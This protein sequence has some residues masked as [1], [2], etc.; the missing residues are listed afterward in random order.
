MGTGSTARTAPTR[1]STPRPKRSSAMPRRCRSA[2]PQTPCRPRPTRSSRGPARRPR[3]G[4]SCWTASPT[5]STTAFDE[6]VPLVTGRDRRH[7]AGLQDHAGA[8]GVGPVPPLRHRGDGVDDRV[9]AAGDHADDRARSRRDHL[10]ASENRAPV[11]V[12]TCITS[13]NFP[14]VNMAGKIGPALAMGNT[15]VVK[16]APQDPLARASG[17]STC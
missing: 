11:G 17:W 7:H 10:R 16:P 2:R 13:Y 12:V 15:V 5:S 4:P 3:T 14:I 6:L 9:D 8:P 1:S